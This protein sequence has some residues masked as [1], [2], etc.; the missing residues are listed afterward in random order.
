MVKGDFVKVI[1]TIFIAVDKTAVKSPSK[2]YYEYEC[3]CQR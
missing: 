3:V 2:S 1:G